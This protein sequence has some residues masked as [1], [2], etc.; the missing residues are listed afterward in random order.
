[1]DLPLHP[2]IIESR[3]LSDSFD[4]VM[5]PGVPRTKILGINIA[6]MRVTFPFPNDN[7]MV[8]P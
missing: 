5:M 7:R 1:M 8:S 2:S 4:Y 3:D 6:L